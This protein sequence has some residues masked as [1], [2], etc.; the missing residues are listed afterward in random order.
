MAEETTTN[1]PTGTSVEDTPNTSAS[2]DVNPLTGS[3]VIKS[4]TGD[5]M[6]NPLTGSAYTTNKKSLG[7]NRNMQF[8]VNLRD[9]LASYGKY[10]ATLSP[11]LDLD[12]ER[13]MRQSTGEK[14]GRG[15]T[16]AL[17]TT[18]GAVAENTLGMVVGIGEAAVNW[19]GTKF[20]DNSVGRKIDK[21]NNY[22]QE[23]MPNYYTQQEQNAQ[24]LAALGFANFWA[25]KAANGL[26]YSL[27]SI[28]TIYLTGGTG[29]IGGAGK[30]LKMA[31][32]AAG[33]G[34]YSKAALAA[35]RAVDTGADVANAVSKGAKISS[36]LK[37]AARAA[38]IGMMMSWAESSVEARETMNSVADTMIAKYAADRGMSPNQVPKEIQTQLRS[39]AASAGNATFGMNL[40]VLTGTNLITFGQ[41]LF[42]KFIPRSK[43]PLARIGLDKAAGKAVDKLAKDPRWLNIAKKYIAPSIEGGVSEG[44]QEATQFAISEAATLRATDPEYANDWF[45]AIAKG[46]GDTYNTKEGFDNTLVGVMVGMLTGGLGSVQTAINKGQ[47]A[48]DQQVNKALEMINNSPLMQKMIERGQHANEI[49]G[50]VA[51]MNAALQTRARDEKGRFTGRPGKHKAYA[52]AQFK[53]LRAEA[54]MHAEMGTM[55][56]FLE[57]LEMEKEKTEE[58]FIQDNLGEGES[59]M[60]QDKNAL[61]DALKK[62]AEDLQTLHDNIESKFPTTERT[63]GAARLFMSKEQ[64]REEAEIIADETF[65][66]RM[67]FN[68]TS[69]LKNIDGRIDNLVAEINKADPDA[70][71][72]A[73][74][75]REAIQTVEG[76]LDVEDRSLPVE[77]PML[78]EQTREKLN[79]ALD[80][81]TVNEGGVA[82]QE[83]KEK[84]DDLILLANDRK[85]AVGALNN[86][87]AVPEMREA[88]LQR[89]KARAEQ[90]KQDKVDQAIRED[91]NETV[92]ESDLADVDTT[93][94]SPAMQEEI[95]QIKRERHEAEAKMRQEVGAM[96]PA[97]I[98]ELLKEEEDPVRKSIMQDEVKKA[99]EEGRTTARLEPVRGEA[100]DL[101][102][103]QERAADAQAAEMTAEATEAAQAQKDADERAADAEAAAAQAEQGIDNSKD[104]DNPEAKIVISYGDFSF[105]A[106]SG[107]SG[108]LKIIVNDQ[109]QPGREGHIKITEQYLESNGFQ[110]NREPLYSEG[111]EG[112]TVEFVLLD[113]PRM[114]AMKVGND[115]IGEVYKNQSAEYPALLD[116]LQKGEKVTAEITGRKFNN[117]NNMVDEQGNQKFVSVN[118]AFEKSE[119]QPILGIIRGRDI[120]DE[121][122]G[123]TTKETY[124]DT[125]RV[126]ED[127]EIVPFDQSQLNELTDVKG[128]SLKPGTVYVMLKQ[129]DGKYRPAAASSRT[130]GQ[131]S[132]AY[133]TAHGL[134][135]S[136][137]EG[138][139]SKLESLVG[140]GPKLNV[141]TTDI[142]GVRSNYILVQDET[143]VVYRMYTDKFAKSEEAECKV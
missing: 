25:D 26:G 107:S 137:K 57:R 7:V 75:V 132:T 48:E 143:G 118:E 42:P 50:H 90:A 53:A 114:I 112:K 121:E 138:A 20:F 35:A 127:G 79:D 54:L 78:D 70:G 37:S 5:P 73:A 111:L 72:T 142:D 85:K 84:M 93:N 62:K 24:G 34:R 71:I 49:A 60:G 139:A 94:A 99:K 108:K 61:V 51:D 105:E 22:M 55:D 126:D 91:I 124:I 77:S 101:T 74:S 10:G 97:A 66:K 13:A 45:K 65:Y 46:Y 11:Y 140:L 1:A 92:K 29:L 39:E 40:A 68:N 116:R 59:L 58:Q 117:F 125:G 18:A 8:N 14:W 52:D 44:F 6:V 109:N 135:K 123:E 76:T 102:Q 88:Y 67:L 2:I 120:V 113:N 27:G 133:Q 4:P 100:T 98:E 122:T 23:V 86:L 36:G 119:E 69:S 38:D 47:T 28:A 129:P 130:I 41:H 16:K 43:G 33:L 96:T 131:S 63:E 31:G 12:Q 104:I 110:L 83:L 30:G 87:S 64:K 81:V 95:A 80:R 136:N 141:L 115:Y 21:I 17:V 89:Q 106:M 15:L 128:A 103:S 134:L 56:V 19:D 82:A 9:P 32:K 3:P